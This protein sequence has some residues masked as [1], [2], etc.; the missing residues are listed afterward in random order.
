MGTFT[1]SILVGSGHPNDGGISPITTLYLN[2]GSKISW[3]MRGARG[4]RQ[5]VTWI[6]S[7]DHTLED[8]ILMI[9]YFVLESSPTRELVKEFA[10]EFKES[11][12]FLYQAFTD[13][14]RKQLY[15]SCCGLEH[16]PKL[17]VSAFKGSHIFSQ[18]HQLPALT[19]GDLEICSPVY[20]RVYSPWTNRV[21]EEGSIL[22]G[23]AKRPF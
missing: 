11:Q 1:A 16:F 23:E 18:L 2:E 6:C 21:V 9:A 3:V 5:E 17:I 10:P 12:A 7:V 14:Q 4:S 20:S 8:A 13:S 15:S 22:D 19:R